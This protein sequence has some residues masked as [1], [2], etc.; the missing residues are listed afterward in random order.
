[1]NSDYILETEQL[2]KE[3]KGFVAVNKVDLRVRRGT[4][5]RS[6]ARTAQA[7]RPASTC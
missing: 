6:S 7:R 5:M 1:L 2:S 4:I 3:F